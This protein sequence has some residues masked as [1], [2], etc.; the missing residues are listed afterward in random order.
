MSYLKRFYNLEIFF[1]GGDAALPDFK[2]GPKFT[3]DPKTA[4]I[5]FTFGKESLATLAL[6]LELGLKPAL[7]YCQEPVQ[8]FEERYK[9]K[10]LAELK[11]QFNVDY[12]FVKHQPGL[13]RYG[14]AF[15]LKKSSEIGWGTQVTLLTLLMVPFIYALKARY[16]I[17]GNEY[18]NNEW[19]L[20]EGWKV[21]PCADQTSAMTKSQNG[22]INLLTNGQS[23]VKSSLEP[24]EEINIFYLLHHRYPKLGRY[25]FSCSAELPLYR[26]SP[27]CHCCYKCVRMYL[28]AAAAGFDPRQLGF[29]KN[30]LDNP[31]LWQHYFGRKIKT[32]PQAEL[33]FAFYLLHLKKNHSV[34]VLKFEKEK[35]PRLKNWPYYARYF[36]SLKPCF[37]LPL[38]YQKALLKIFREELSC[39]K[40]SFPHA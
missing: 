27:W 30:L 5:P 33:D 8:P 22:L 15:G 3:P 31:G 38:S 20:R 9:L 21:F 6:C 34:C 28:F 25:Q 12:Y 24:L 10:K 19:K 40:K 35:L 1:K 14:R 11:K 26:G 17:F 16:L 7:V 4:V 29:K 18:S 32:G 36:S 2:A 37:N 39:F 13:F 23:A